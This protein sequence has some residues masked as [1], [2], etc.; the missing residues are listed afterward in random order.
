[1]ISSTNDTLEEVA[2]ISYASQAKAQ[3]VIAGSLD[4]YWP[5]TRH[6]TAGCPALLTANCYSIFPSFPPLSLSRTVFSQKGEGC[7]HGPVFTHGLIM[8]IIF[9]FSFTTT[10]YDSSSQ[11]YKVPTLLV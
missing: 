1:M 8:Y 2:N 9:S 4:V 7:K 10:I 5:K 3:K 11:S 6:S